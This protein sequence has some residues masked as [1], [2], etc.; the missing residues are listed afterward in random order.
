MDAVV[1][2]IGSDATAT[3]LFRV[4]VPEAQLTELRAH[5][6]YV[7]ARKRTRRGHVA[8]NTARDGREGR[9]LLGG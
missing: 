9:T 2:E 4:D 1:E 8:G 3:R 5:Q 7:V 6:A